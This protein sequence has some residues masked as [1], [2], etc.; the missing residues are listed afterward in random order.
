M[1]KMETLHLEIR[2]GIAVM[3][4]NRPDYLNSLTSGALIELMAVF[5]ELKVDKNVRVIILTGAGNKAFCTGADLHELE[6]KDAVAGENYSAQAQQIFNLIEDMEKPVIAAVNGY[7]LGGGCELALACTIRIAQTEAKFGFPETGL[8]IIPAFGG[9]Y[10]LTRQVGLGR[11]LDLILTGRMISGEEAHAIGLATAVT[12][13]DHLME[14]ARSIAQEIKSNAPLA[15]RW[16]MQAVYANSEAD[17]NQ[18]LEL[19]SALFGLSLST[20]DR[21]EGI[22]AFFEKRDAQFAGE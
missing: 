12:D 1:K 22:K 9:T 21:A 20:K 11:A 17:R 2:D 15:V 7:A 5:S 8:G 6:E 10:R 16:A 19:E 4:L 18:S 14:R 13:A 3:T